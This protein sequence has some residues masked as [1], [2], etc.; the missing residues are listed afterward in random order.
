MCKSK[1]SFLV[2][3]LVLLILLCSFLHMPKTKSKLE[4]VL[5]KNKTE[6]VKESP[7]VIVPEVK[8]EV[9]EE[10]APKEEPKPEPVKVVEKPKPDLD[11]DGIA[12]SED[13]DTDGDGLLNVDE[14]ALGSDILIKDTDKDGK[15]DGEEGNKDT[16]GDGK[17]D[18]IE[19]AKLDSD[20]DGVVDELDSE[21]DNP[22]N[23]SDG[24][25]FSNIDEKN[26]NTDPLDKDKHPVIDKDTDK[27]GKLDSI[28]ANKDT[29]GDGKA[30]V[31]ES[32]KLDSDN[33]GVVDEL[34][35]E[36]DNPK[37]D[38]DGDGFSNIDEKKA[39]TDPLDKDKHPVID[40]DTDKDGKLD[41][42][43]ANKDTDG[44]GI[45]DVYESAKLDS[46]NDGVV[47]ELD[48]EDN[49]T[50][51]DTDGDGFSNIVEKNANTNPLDSMEHPEPAVKKEVSQEVKKE[52]Q[53]DIKAIFKLHKVEFEVN[54]AKLTNEGM[55]TVGKVAEVLKKYPKIVIE[56][57][58]HTDSD[59]KADYNMRLSQQRVDEVKKELVGLKID[60]NRLKP[61]GYGETKPLV[62]N[63]T[64]ENKARNRRVEFIII[65]GE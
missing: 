16:D 22:A 18:V 55:A 32:A 42:I 23:D 53:E 48:S 7:K 46:D 51:N 13:N 20:N 61:V 3:L 15:L 39:N 43:E 60:A 24:D 29:D 36:N 30:D 65:G 21:N 50:Q 26:A 34:D 62:P 17:A 12:D 49:N 58:G 8:E 6:V 31:I 52:F 56:I 2:C 47:D 35:S 27:D 54:S 59:G 4:Q 57:A 5:E 9:K 28:E 38:S 19:S 10:V 64:P 44:D 41:S 33:D 14:K 1:V 25:G 45:A 37:N 11:G 40:K 63:D